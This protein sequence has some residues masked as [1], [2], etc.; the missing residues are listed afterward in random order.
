MKRKFASFILIC[1]LVLFSFCTK[2][3]EGVKWVN[4]SADSI[5]KLY[6]SSELINDSLFIED[7]KTLASLYGNDNNNLIW[8]NGDA[9]IHPFAF[10]LIEHTNNAISYGLDPEFYDNEVLKICWLFIPM[11]PKFCIQKFNFYRKYF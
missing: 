6:F 11:L 7:K 2:K 3:N 5:L 8:F 1:F 4:L 9:Q 10:E